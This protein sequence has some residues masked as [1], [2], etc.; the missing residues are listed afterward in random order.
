MTHDE[1]LKACAHALEK[2]PDVDKLTYYDE[3]EN[4]CWLRAKVQWHDHDCTIFVPRKAYAEVVPSG[5][6]DLFD[7]A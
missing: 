7:P 1:F 5:Q 3:N 4:G 2:V 6:R